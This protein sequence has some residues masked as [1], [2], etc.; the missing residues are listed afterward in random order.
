[1]LAKRL[2]ILLIIALEGCAVSGSIKHNLDFAQFKSVYFDDGISLFDQ[3]YMEGRGTF[4]QSVLD[5]S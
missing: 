1:M 5:G 2:L 3:K 4:V